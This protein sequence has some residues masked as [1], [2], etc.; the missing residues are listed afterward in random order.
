MIEIATLLQPICHI[1]CV[2]LSLTQ[3]VPNGFTTNPGTLWEIGAIDRSQ[4]IGGVHRA[5]IQ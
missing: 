5:Y 4:E 2:M 3:T 1:R